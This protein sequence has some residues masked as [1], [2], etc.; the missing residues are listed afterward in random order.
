[1]VTNLRKTNL[2]LLPVLRELLRHRNVTNAARALNLSQPAVSNALAQLRILFHD[3]LLI[4]HGRKL[5]PSALAERMLP[6]LEMMLGGLEQFI[7]PENFDPANSEGA[8]KIATAD[9]VIFL[10][11]PELINQLSARAPA[12]TVEFTDA[13]SHS[14]PLLKMG[15]I[16]LFIGPRTLAHAAFDEFSVSTLFDDDI[17]CIVDA[18]ESAAR[19]IS[20]E[21]LVERKLV[22]FTPAGSETPA[23]FETVLQHAGVTPRNSVRVPSFLIIPYL[24]QGTGAIALLQR[25]LAE[26]LAASTSIRIM[27]PPLRF[28]KLE[29]GMWWS[30]AREHD[31]SHIWLRQLLSRIC[32]KQ[33]P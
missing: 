5:Q 14:A 12:L 19:A 6:R 13:G 15:D 3:E 32:E 9:Y 33:F 11:G 7:T 10:L 17:V 18:A 29:I 2:N 24:V 22:L 1:M 30:P 27:A 16:D 20:A 25:R 23:F 4:P 26:R 31:P 21:D 8:I 28:P